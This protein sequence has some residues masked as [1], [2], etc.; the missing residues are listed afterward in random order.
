MKKKDEREI[1]DSC[2]NKAK[3]DETVFVIL[4][5]DPAFAATVRFWIG[6]R[7]R[8]G[9]NKLEDAKIKTAGDTADRVHLEQLA[10][11]IFKQPL[12]KNSNA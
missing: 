3:E 2:W 5:R 12:E 8:L 7:L 4:D 9:I 1:Q 11:K 10:K 6:E